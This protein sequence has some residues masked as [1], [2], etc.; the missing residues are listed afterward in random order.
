MVRQIDRWLVRQI[1][2]WLDRQIDIWLDRQ[3]GGQIDRWLDRQID[4]QM[5]SQMVRWIAKWLDEQMV[6]WL[7]GQKGI[8]YSG[9]RITRRES[10][11]TQL[12]DKYIYSPYTDIL[13]NILFIKKIN[14]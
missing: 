6:R 8:P 11:V 13:Y 14:K 7:D 3:L 1:D 12:L 4:G 9:Y 10:E 5:D 2:R